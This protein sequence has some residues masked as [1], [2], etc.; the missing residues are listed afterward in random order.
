MYKQKFLF[1]TKI[2]YTIILLIVII[3][4]IFDP[5][6]YAN[7]T[8]NAIMLWGKVILPTLLPFFFITK[9]INEL[10]GIEKISKI[11]SKPMKKL[12]NCPGI[13]AYVFF[14]SILS[15]YPMGAKITTDLY[16]NKVINQKHAFSILSFCSTSGPMFILASV[17]IGMFFDIKIGFVLLASHILGTIINGFLYRAKKE[18]VANISFVKS[19]SKNLLNDSMF[20]SINAVLM[21]CGFMCI[22]FVLIEIINTLKINYPIIYLFDTILP[23]KCGSA[24]ANGLLEV[25]RGCLDISALNM[26]NVVSVPLASFLIGFGGIS[27]H[28]Q[29]LIFIKQFNMPYKLFLLQKFTQ[30]IISCVISF[31]LCLFI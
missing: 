13:S 24:F 27:I 29:S 21:I 7:A 28:L 20:S 14:M 3:I 18:K 11:F 17:G 31:L 4:I 10:N 8:S 25:T 15:G 6:K 23:N 12:Y 16:N 19:Q 2:F 9:I 26:T 22:S 1:D 5:I 30:G